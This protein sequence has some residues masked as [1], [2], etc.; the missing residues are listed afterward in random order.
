[1]SDNY[2]VVKQI[3]T[4]GEHNDGSTIQVNLMSWY[5]RMPVLDIRKWNK[6]G[7][8]TKGVC[9]SKDELEELKRVINNITM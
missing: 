2:E 1:M 4:L 8:P 7:R 6:E 5:R 3:A 9:L